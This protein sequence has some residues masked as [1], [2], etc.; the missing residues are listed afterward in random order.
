MKVLV[1]VYKEE[2]F[3]TEVIKSYDTLCEVH[4]SFDDFWLNKG[5]YDIIHLHWPEYIVKGELPTDI[6]LLVLKRVLEEWQS[7]N[8]KIVITRHNYLPHKSDN[9]RFKTL[10]SLI[11]SL[12]DAVIHMGEYSIKEYKY[13]YV[14]SI[15]KYQLQS[16]IPHPLFTQ[17]PNAISKKE[18]R[19]KLKIKDST[20]V[21]LVF[22]SVRNAVE[23][24]LILSAFKD[25]AIKD[26]VL[27]VPS[28]NF[29]K[30][31]EPVNRIQWF[32]INKSKRYRI[33][34]EFIAN[35]DVQYYFKASD[36]V[37]LPRTD[38]LNSG[39]PF[40]SAV[41]NT[42]TVG[43]NTGNIGEVLKANGM[44]TFEGLSSE[45]IQSAINKARLITKDKENYKAMK[46]YNST[47]VV[48]DKHIALFQKLIGL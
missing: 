46:H 2:L 24:N 48:G 8:T 28:W 19:L 5:D 7:K 17:Y 13:R 4:T 31:K 22:G 34:N 29:S 26:K 11:Y 44:P 41:F 1:P 43:S 18:A 27:I 35:S 21:M 12:A 25:I 9:E 42:P 32:M 39:V 14:D 45:Q 15:P 38:T 10:Y 37:F 6:E 33:F 23:K 36:F 3:I 16:Y 30:K 47:E 40:L 20:L